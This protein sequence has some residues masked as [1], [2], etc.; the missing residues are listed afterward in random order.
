MV[1]MEN[2][3]GPRPA[4]IEALPER[5]RM[6]HIG[7]PKTG[8]TSVQAAA[9]AV[10]SELLE[11]GVRYPGQGRSQYAAVAS[12]L[13][14][15][16]QFTRATEAER[17]RPPSRAAWRKMM[18]EIE[19]DQV[20]RIWFGH[21]F[22]AAAT[23]AEARAFANQIG[24]RIHVVVTLRSFTRMLPSIWQE[25]NKSGNTVG[26]DRFVKK[27][28][29]VPEE[30]REDVKFHL[31]HNQGAL[32]RRWAE[33]IGP[34]NVTVVVA[35][36]RDHSFTKHAFED[37]LGLPRGLVA[38]A[39]ISARQVNRSMSA[40]EIEL[41]RQVN[42]ELRQYGLSWRDYEALMVHGGLF[43]MLN[44]RKPAPDEPKL[45]LSRWGA[46]AAEEF[47]AR[48]VEVLQSTGVRIIGDV[49][50]LLEPAQVRQS[51]LENHRHVQ[52][53]PIDAAV[54][55]TVGVVGAARS[56]EGLTSTHRRVTARRIAGDL[57]RVWR[58][59]LADARHQ[60]NER[61]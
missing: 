48:S 43:H 36:R 7:P 21:E 19:A 47:Q 4:L 24:P 17:Q 49:A 52:Q 9:A 11:H 20:S 58:E 55:L 6:F 34:E 61:P 8:T 13:G 26:F 28:L 5:V 46:R 1:S 31:R 35:D 56:M 12:F 39:T 44:D 53:I 42:R 41:A 3:P 32:V 25:T 23:P 57:L 38:D 22:A 10:R 60:R 15:S 40:P 14:R 45:R 50:N 59:I 27:M 30:R 18:A 16:N 29:T 2:E 33:L 37:L 54:K 51:E